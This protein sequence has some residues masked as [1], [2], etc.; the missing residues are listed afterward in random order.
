VCAATLSK[1]QGLEDISEAPCQ[2][3]TIYQ[4]NFCWMR[5]TFPLSGMPYPLTHPNSATT[6]GIRS[7]SSSFGNFSH[8]HPNQPLS[9]ASNPYPSHLTLGTTSS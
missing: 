5:P 4:R 7:N 3:W 8:T 9:S 6:L 1:S 2:P